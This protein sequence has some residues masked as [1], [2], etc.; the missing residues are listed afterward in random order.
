[1]DEKAVCMK[2]YTAFVKKGVSDEQKSRNKKLKK[3]RTLYLLAIPSI[4]Y[5]NTD[6][7]CNEPR[8]T[9][10]NMRG[11]R[12]Q[13]WKLMD[14]ESALRA[15]S[16]FDLPLTEDKVYVK[17]VNVDSKEKEMEPHLTLSAGY[18]PTV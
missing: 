6:V 4:A 15:P 9:G 5:P 3:Y 13:I 1:M 8:D 2:V 12:N 10:W 14:G 11:V 7:G 17:L 18:L 16:F